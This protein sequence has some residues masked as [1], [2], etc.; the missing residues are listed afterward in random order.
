VETDETNRLIPGLAV[1]W[2]NVGDTTW[3][4][5]LRQ[6]VLWHDGSPFTAED[7]KFTFERAPNVPNSPSGFAG[8]TRGKHIEII[9]D[10]TI[11]I[12]TAAPYA[13]MLND[14]ANL[15]IISKK[16]GQGAKTEDYN[17]GKS[18]I[19]TGPF[20]LVE[21]K[22]GE[23][24]V[25]A[26]SENHWRKKSPWTKLVFRIIGS[27]PARVAALLNGDVDIIEDVPTVA[28]EWLKADQR[29]KLSQ[30]LSRRLIYFH[31]DQFRDQTPFIK[32]KDGSSIRNPL[33]DRRVRLA[34]SKA[35]DRDVITKKV[36]QGLAIPASQFLPD[37]FSGISHRLRPVA[38]DPEG[39][40]K[41]LADAGF[42]AG[43]K[44]TLHGPN[45]RYT[46][47]AK[48][49]EA[50]AQMLTRV[51]LD[52]AFEALPP[53]TFFSRASAG[54]NGQPAFSFILA[55]WSAETG[56]TLGA[57]RPLVGTYDPDKGRGMANRGRYSDPVVDDLIDKAAATIDNERRG[58]LLA[59]AVERAMERV[60]VIP[61]QHPINTWASRRGL[62]I[63]ARIDERT[64]AMG[65]V[66]D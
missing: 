66:E 22:P 7:V 57:L 62:T 48:I 52:I 36:M 23:R 10:H 18:A 60:A 14:L 59:E 45:G 5:R 16:H 9:D 43:F 32:A 64:L 56:E 46:N 54:A 12:S 44:M 13:L 50:V 55:G 34:L 41:L 27:G 28:I 42:P 3:E 26:A 17:S 51:G 65:I 20:K 35:I 6:G 40:K 38:Y 25:L 30:G 11:R 63:P 4:F 37:G 39:A 24:I 15:L 19:G 33:K 58:E 31:M 61:V 53:A 47:D 49:L 29:V 8:V 21:F 1:S 2:K